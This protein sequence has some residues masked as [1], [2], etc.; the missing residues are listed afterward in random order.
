MSWLVKPNFELPEKFYL[1]EDSEYLFLHRNKDG[2]VSAVFHQHT[3]P[4][5]ILQVCEEYL[6]AE[7]LELLR[8][9]GEVN[10]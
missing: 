4:R 3:T 7:E 1:T 9:R 5:K 6:A 10:A 2:K 8:Q